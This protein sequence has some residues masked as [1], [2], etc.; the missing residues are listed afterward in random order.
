MDSLMSGK[1]TVEVRGCSF[2]EEYKDFASDLIAEIEKKNH[3]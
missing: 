3:S 2:L 1:L